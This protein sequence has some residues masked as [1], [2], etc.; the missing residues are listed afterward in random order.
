MLMEINLERSSMMVP[1]LLDWSELTR[2]LVWTI[3]HSTALKIRQSS[4][5]QI[6]EYDDDMLKTTTGKEILSEY[7]QEEE[8]SFPHPKM[9]SVVIVSSP[10]K[11][12]D[13]EKT[14]I[15]GVREI[16]NIQQQPNSS[17]K[18]LTTLSRSI[19]GM[20]SDKQEK[21]LA[22]PKR[23]GLP[24][25]D[26]NRPIVQPNSL[27][28][29]LKG[30]STNE[31]FEELTRKLSETS[32][33]KEHVGTS[34]KKE[35]RQMMIIFQEMFVAATSYL[36]RMSQRE[37]V[38]A[39]TV[40]FKGNLR[41]WWHNHLTDAN[42]EAIKDAVLEKTEQGP[43]DDAVTIQPNSVNTFVYVAIKHFVGRMTLY[44]DQSMEALLGMKCPKMSDFKWKK[45]RSKKVFKKSKSSES[46]GYSNR[47]ERLSKLMN[48]LPKKRNSPPRKKKIF[49]MPFLEESSE[50]PSSFENE[51]D[52][53][54]AIPCSGYIN[55]LTSIQK[56]LLDIIKEVD[57][58][59]I[60][61]KIL[62]RLLEDLET[63]DIKFKDPMNFS[64]QALMN[65][66][67]K[68]HAMLVKV[69]DLQHE[70]KV[71]KKEIN[72]NMQQIPYLENAVVAI[73]E[74]IISKDSIETP[75]NEINVINKIFN[76]KW[77]TK[78]TLKIKDYKFEATVLIDSGADQN[79]IQE[80]IILSKYFK[81]AR[82][83]LKE[84]GNNSLRINYELSKVHVC[85]DEVWLVHSFLL[86]KRL[87]EEVVLGTP[88]LTQ[89]Y[90]FTVSDKDLT[91]QKFGKKIIFEFCKPVIQRYL[92]SIE[93]EIVQS[94][95][96]ISKKEKQIEF[97][98]D[99]IKDVKSVKKSIN[100]G[101]K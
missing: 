24:R 72:E 35:I 83:S 14:K 10:Y 66:L 63:P 99:D 30:S 89:I 52:I 5:T 78:V 26:P 61:K 27:D 60:R 96:L 80:G 77:L 90:P 92:S 39:L 3:E 68:E 91:S 54:D 42:R 95:N 45:I 74:Q 37:I 23:L 32:I 48:Y 15:V 43:N 31:L 4:T 33:S 85:K 51:T 75:S 71:L 34:S 84:A 87:T 13:E 6:T 7:P 21:T 49:S 76:K 12:I 64:F 20:K 67:S 22:P 69:T 86:I 25:V 40:G 9:P 98:H 19:E 16:K 59:V 55:I 18:G 8:A 1:K 97:L 56:G 11:T 44:S 36:R 62:F 50:E 17:N 79:V 81:I 58:D 41:S 28:I 88:F 53:E 100:L 2:N 57:D 101:S 94:L 82:E 65:Q 47:K 93:N 73:Q 38:D 46:Y 29:K 70:I